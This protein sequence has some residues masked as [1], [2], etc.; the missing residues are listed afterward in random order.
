MYASENI[1]NV[2]KVLKA[3]KMLIDV[4]RNGSVSSVKICTL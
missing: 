4:K 1:M 2:Y 3:V